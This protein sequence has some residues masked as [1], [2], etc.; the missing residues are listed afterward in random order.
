MI[1]KFFY[2]QLFIYLY[3]KL[4]KKKIQKNLSTDGLPESEPPKLYS[5]L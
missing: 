1:L 5:K 2:N 3:T 4:F